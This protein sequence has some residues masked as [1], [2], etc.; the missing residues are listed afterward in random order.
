ML[1]KQGLYRQVMAYPWPAQCVVEPC[2]NITSLRDAHGEL[3]NMRKVGGFGGE[4][5]GAG[6]MES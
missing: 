1:E 6:W 5:S 3:G 4:E 2:I